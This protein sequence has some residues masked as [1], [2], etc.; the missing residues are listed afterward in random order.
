VQVQRERWKRG[1]QLTNGALG[2]AVGA[3]YVEPNFPPA[4]ES[5]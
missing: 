2:E 3:I 4:A 1:I 5:R